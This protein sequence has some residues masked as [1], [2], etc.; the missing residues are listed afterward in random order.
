MAQERAANQQ[1]SGPKSTDTTFRLMLTGVDEIGEEDY[2]L[3]INAKNSTSTNKIVKTAR[4]RYGN[5]V[6]VHVRYQ[7]KLLPQNKRVRDLGIQGDA[8]LYMEKVE[9]EPAPKQAKTV[10]TEVITQPTS[11]AVPSSELELWRQDWESAKTVYASKLQDEQDMPQDTA[12]ALVKE[13][14]SDERLAGVYD[15]WNGNG[16][17]FKHGKGVCYGG[18]NSRQLKRSW[19]GVGGKH[20]P[21][22]D[23]E[24]QVTL[25]FLVTAAVQSS[26][27]SQ[28]AEQWQARNH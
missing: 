26:I 10:E 4:E 2:K 9:Y 24:K 17:T 12:D 5:G 23:A 1:V 16:L 3:T 7:G 15:K 27:I 25:P 18:K 19:E 22:F 20:V 11:S 6:W 13:V 28:A 21:G 8:Q 14:M